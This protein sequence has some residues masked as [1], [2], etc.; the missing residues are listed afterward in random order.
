MRLRKIVLISMLA[1]S[2]AA[3]SACSKKST[4]STASQESS[5]TTE[6]TAAV[7]RPKDYGTV[8]LSDYKGVEIPNIDTTVT[9]DEVESQINTNLKQDPNIEEITDRAVQDGDT[10]NIDYTGTKDGVA[11]DGGSATG[12]DLVIGS[13]SFIDGFESGLIGHNIGEDVKLEL[14]FPSDYGNEDLAGAAV[15]FDVKINSISVSKDAELNDEWVSRHTNGEC[16]TVDAYRASVRKELEEQKQK[17]AQSQDQYNAISAVIDKSTFKMNDKAIDYEYNNIYAPIESM[18]NQYGMSLEDYA[19][20]YGMTEDQLKTELKTQAEG[21]VKQTAAIREI[22]KKEK[23]SLNDEDYQ[24]LID[25]NGG[26][27]T[28]DDLIKQYGQ[29]TIDEAAKTYKVVNFLV[30]NA[31]RTD[32]TVSVT[33]ETLSGQESTESATEGAS[34]TASEKETKKAE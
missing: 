34:G 31:K 16:T 32:V 15:V 19:K 20:A 14:T 13:K 25:M 4:D 26:N 10:V 2:I 6:T 9:D 5:A 7:D 24:I 29:D 30:D 12:F 17:S 33:G 23:M 8:K 28:K 22:F 18:I 1:V 27:T 21:Y 3:V 11:F